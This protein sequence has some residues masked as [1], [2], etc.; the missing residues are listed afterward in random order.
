MTTFATVYDTLLTEVQA[1]FM[2]RTRLFDA[3]DP[4]NNPEQMLRS[5]WGLRKTSTD[6]A[7]RE[8]CSF[9]MAHGFECVLTQ[10]IVR[11]ETQV[12]V[13]DDAVKTLID[14]ATAVQER[15]YRFDELGIP[16]DITQV[17]LGSLSAVEKLLVGNGRF[18]TVSVAFIVH[19]N[20]NF[21]S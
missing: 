21:K 8:F 18:I 17:D 7:L 20:E 19:V 15:V 5:G 1:L 14:D 4:A 9:D 12:S 16:A 3:Y 10:E 13:L 6:P 2:G 11:A